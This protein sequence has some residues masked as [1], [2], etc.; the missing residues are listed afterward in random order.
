MQQPRAWPCTEAK[1]GFEHR[2]GLSKPTTTTIP[3]ASISKLGN[4]TI[5]TLCFKGWRWGLQQQAVLRA[6]SLFCSGSGGARNATWVG[7]LLVHHQATPDFETVLLYF[8][9][10]HKLLCHMCLLTLFLQTSRE[11]WPSISTVPG[12][13][14]NK[15]LV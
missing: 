9:Y 1:L 6:Y 5:P 2:A 13:W 14:L 12:I 11:G 8:H 3:R 7:C 15:T 10:I 4:P